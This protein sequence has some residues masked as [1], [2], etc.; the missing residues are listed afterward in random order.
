MVLRLSMLLLASSTAFSLVISGVARGVDSWQFLSRFIFLPT[1]SSGSKLDWV[2]SLPSS[3]RAELLL[4][5]F[6]FVAWRAFLAEPMNCR[7]RIMAAK[8]STRFTSYAQD[9]VLHVT[10]AARLRAAGATVRTAAEDAAAQRRARDAALPHKVSVLRNASAATGTVPPVPPV[11]PPPVPGTSFTTHRGSVSFDTNFAVVWF[12][13][14]AHCDVG[15]NASA[16][17]Y[18]CQAPL[19]A[20][21]DVTF[22]NG[23]GR[24]RNHFSADEHGVWAQFITFLTLQVCGCAAAA[25]R[26]SSHSPLLLRA[27][28]CLLTVFCLM[29]SH[30]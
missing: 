4:Y 13:A 26:Q 5:R 22:S 28:A 23:G 18:G 25:D 12:L 30:R 21:Y 24:S 1:V 9:D 15:C 2:V 16:A 7:Q 11:V 6:D 27:D 20:A 10:H 8:Y 3:S 19:E 14:F 17:A 29:F